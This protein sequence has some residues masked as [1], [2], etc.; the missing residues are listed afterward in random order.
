MCGRRLG[1]APEDCGGP[2]AFL[3]RR[4]AA[5]WRVEELLEGLREDLNAG[6]IATVQDRLE[7]L[8][9]WQEWLLLDRFDRRAVNGWLRR[10]AQ[11]DQGWM[12]S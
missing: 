9:P 11:G 7:Q 6:D 8:Q 2:K 3:E 12:D 1:R 10:Y 4:A 5:P